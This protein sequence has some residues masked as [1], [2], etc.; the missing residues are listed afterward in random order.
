MITDR[1]RIVLDVFGLLS[2]Y[3]SNT[4][5]QQQCKPLKLRSRSWTGIFKLSELWKLISKYY[6]LVCLTLDIPSVPGSGVLYDLEQLEIYPAL[7]I[8]MQAEKKLKKVLGML[9]ANGKLIH[10]CLALRAHFSLCLYL[11]EAF[12]TVL[13]LSIEW[14]DLIL[15]SYKR[16]LIR[17]LD[18]VVACLSFLEYVSLF[19]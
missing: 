15:V 14:H 17:C 6:G 1:L 7:D 2:L 19:L 8:M 16:I 9:D 5:S 12:R 11:I 13:N 4:S 18:D 3:L 10:L